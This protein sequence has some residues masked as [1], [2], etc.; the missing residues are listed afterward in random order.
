M[1]NAMHSIRFCAKAGKT[2]KLRL[3]CAAGRMLVG[4]ILV[5]PTVFLPSTIR[6][7]EKSCADQPAT[8]VAVTLN[9]DSAK[10]AKVTLRDDQTYEIAVTGSAPTIG[11]LLHGEI[12]TNQVCVLAFEYFSLHAGEHVRAE[13]GPASGDTHVFLAAGL[14]HSEAFSSYSTNLA[15]SPDWKGN[16]A[17]FRIGFDSAP[18]QV[19]RLR[20]VTLRALSDAELEKPSRI[21]KERA[22]DKQLLSGLTS[23]LGRQY[24]EKVTSVYVG[25]STVRIE[26][27]TDSDN[28]ELYLAEVPLYENITELHRFDYVTKITSSEH[29]FQIELSRFRTLP[30]GRYDR[31]LSKWAIVR[32]SASGFNLVSHAR[33]PDEVKPLW[34]YADEQPRCKKGLGGV[35]VDHGLDDLDQLGGVCSI[36]VN[37]FLDFMHSHAKPGDISFSYAGQVYFAD[38]KAISDYD[39][40]L[41]FAAQRHIVASAIILVRPVHEFYDHAIGT[42][43]A[44]PD[45]D[46]SGL[47][48]MPNITNLDSLQV[49]AA[50]LN[51]LAERYSRADEQYGRIQNWIMH[52]EVD[53]GWIWTNA[54]EKSELTYMNLYNKSMRAMYLIARQ[55]NP[56]SKVF[57]SL[58]HFWNW[59][60]DS[61]FYLGRKMLSDLVT[62]SH[63]EGDYEWAI[64]YHPYPESLFQSRAWEDKKVT[65]SFDTPLITFKNIEVLN[66]WVQQ[67]STFYRGIKR[68]SI[69]LSEQGFNSP[70]YSEKSF[71]NQ[72]AGLAYAWK[73]IESLDTIEA[74]DYHNWIDDRGEGGLRIRLRKYRDDPTDPTDKKPIWYLY[75]KLG[76]P[77]EDKASAFALPVIGIH[78]WNEVPYLG[79]L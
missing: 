28:E 58:T 71:T 12:N 33:Y 31:L 18:G 14:S 23:Y 64:A 9:P 30:D 65:F 5:V 70:D 36:T 75:Q 16:I 74:M 53:A 32:K 61:H 72:A 79:K 10:D 47:Y 1:E 15:K 59:T 38:A 37:I 63:A 2:A 44:H 48:A 7:S 40:V 19:I 42:L 13:F 49:Y 8:Q 45:A 29:R 20:N 26:G 67:P 55:Y 3:A 62:Y 73:K 56:H 27:S 68:R 66:A 54:G 69:F 39:R 21:A 77:E 41:Q 43:M 76:T 51:F 60:E 6:A 34:N 35:A 52:N 22:D 78:D 50:A 11:I 17:F 25:N 46:P 24:P 57:I 4:A